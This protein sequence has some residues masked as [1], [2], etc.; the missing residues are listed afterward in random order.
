VIIAAEHVVDR[1]DGI[2]DPLGHFARREMGEAGFRQ[3]AVPSLTIS[4]LSSS[5]VWSDR[6]PMMSVLSAK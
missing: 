5:R 6:R 3:Q 4:S 1:A 2:A